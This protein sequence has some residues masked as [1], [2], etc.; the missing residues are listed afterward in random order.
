MAAIPENFGVGGSGLTPGGGSGSPDL[1]EVTRDIADDLAELRAQFIA[2]LTKL[3]VDS[4]DTGGDSNYASTLTPD[5]LLTT[6][7]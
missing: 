2:L 1:A 7:A 5:P 6:K 3:D 4:G